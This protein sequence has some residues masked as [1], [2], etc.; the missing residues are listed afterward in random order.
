MA[1]TTPERRG[2]PEN[3]QVPGHLIPVARRAGR[4]RL[5][6]RAF[7]LILVLSVIYVYLSHRPLWHTDLWGHLAYGRLI[8]TERAI[9]SIEPFMPLSRGVRFVDFSWLSQVLGYAAF[10]WEGIAAIQSLYAASITLSLGLLAYGIARRTQ[11]IWPELA[12]LGACTWLEWQ[13]F[14]IVRPQLAGLACFVLLFVSLAQKRP[15]NERWFLVPLVLA[16]WT[17]L[18]GSFLIGLA[19]VLTFAVGRG[20]DVLRRTATWRAVGLDGTF[21][22]YAILFVPAALAVLLN[23]YGW[24]IFRAVWETARNPNLADLVE[25]RPLT[26]EMRQGQAAAVIALAL[27]VFYR[28]TPRR[29]SSS[30]WLLLV[31]LGA[32]SL[33]SSRMIVWWAPVASYYLAI[34]GAAIRNR[35]RGSVRRSEVG[36]RRRTSPAWAFA[37]VLVICGAAVSSPL[38]IVLLHHGRADPERSLSP[39][40]PLAA[41]EYLNAHPPR[42]QIFNTYEW[43][44]YLI[45][46]GPKGLRVFVA[47]HAH[48]V[49]AD[50][51]QDYM[52]VITL[53]SGWQQILDRYRVGVAVLDPDQQGDLVDALRD[54]PAWSIADEDERS[55][56]FVRRHGVVPMGG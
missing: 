8:V 41:T 26:I 47:S 52:R 30:E 9:P 22:T 33:H 14:L 11:S 15:G 45:W 10:R 23:P 46:A 51:W 56:I 21:R 31:G 53:K 55:V 37:A 5:S 36:G 49:P 3:E 2:D 40:T 42:G 35:Y 12:A 20:V 1:V 34:H 39:Q 4:L 19:L 38:G 17:N 16:L 48:L 54:S 13:Q 6:R 29:V 28:L 24:S 43:G 44:D 18:H 7:V 27:I 50:V 32:A 25:W